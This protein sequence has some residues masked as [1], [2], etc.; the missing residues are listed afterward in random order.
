MLIL[1]QI[2]GEADMWDKLRQRFG[3]RKA[4][5][6]AAS[7]GEEE[8]QPVPGDAGT[9]VV[10]ALRYTCPNPE[11]DNF[12]KFATLVEL[13]EGRQL[14]ALDLDAEIAHYGIGGER[15]F[16]DRLRRVRCALADNPEFLAGLQC[17]NAD[18]ALAGTQILREIGCSDVV[19]GILPLGR[20]SEFKLEYRP[21]ENRFYCY[22]RPDKAQSVEQRWPE[23]VECLSH[24]GPPFGAHWPGIHRQSRNGL[25]ALETGRSTEEDERRLDADADRDQSYRQVVPQFGTGLTAHFLFTSPEEQKRGFGNFTYRGESYAYEDRAA[26]DDRMVMAAD[27]SGLFENYAEILHR[28]FPAVIEA[29]GSY[30][31][32]MFYGLHGTRYGGGWQRDNPVYRQLSADPA[33]DVDGRNNIFTLEPAMYW[34]AQLCRRALGYD[35]DEVIRRLRGEVPLVM[36]LMDGVYTV[37]NDAHDLGYEEFLAMNDRFKPILGLI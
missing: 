29:Y 15:E 30:R 1:P 17:A 21:V 7:S 35:R 16:T 4:E 25:A 5:G 12:V 6:E 27:N 34:D 2:K 33:I 24:L 8:A 36:P 18:L 3:G 22:R 10:P 11:G 13:G 26:F 19:A 14:L 37:F 9:R 23:V 31:A 32:V 28:R 20:E